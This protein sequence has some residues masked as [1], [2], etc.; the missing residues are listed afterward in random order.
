M[1][2]WPLWEEDEVDTRSMKENL[3]GFVLDKIFVEILELNRNYKQ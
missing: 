3:E 1:V 2:V